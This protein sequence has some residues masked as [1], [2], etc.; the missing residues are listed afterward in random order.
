MNDFLVIWERVFNRR[1]N[2]GES[3]L[4]EIWLAL[5]LRNCDL[6]EGYALT[7]TEV[8]HGKSATSVELTRV[9]QEMGT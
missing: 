8:L 1:M 7:S 2:T 9:T 3:I 6:F 5:E 4:N